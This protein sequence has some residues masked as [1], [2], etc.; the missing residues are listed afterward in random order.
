MRTCDRKGGFG[1]W[2][3][4]L[5]VTL[6]GLLLLWVHPETCQTQGKAHEAIVSS[7]DC[8]YDTFGVW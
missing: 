4:A 7:S 6:L 1:S 8:W 2:M 5:Q 3:A